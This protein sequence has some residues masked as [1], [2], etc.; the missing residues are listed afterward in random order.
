M[1]NRLGFSGQGQIVYGC[2][3]TMRYRLEIKEEARQ[4]L[5]AL[6]KEQRRNVGRR[7]DATRS[8]RGREKTQ[9]ENARV[10]VAR[11]HVAGA[12]HSGKR[13]RKRSD[14]QASNMVAAATA[15]ESCR[16]RVIRSS[17]VET[18]AEQMRFAN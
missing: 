2:N 7:L 13:Q 12:F 6:A 11:G 9:C 18:R 1:S 5:K 3:T 17:R 4:Q 10:S 15:P 14:G 16:I 8:F